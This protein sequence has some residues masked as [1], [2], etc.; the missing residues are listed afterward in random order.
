MENNLPNY[1][2]FQLSFFDKLREGT[3]KI[4]QQVKQLNEL[5]A[6]GFMAKTPQE[7]EN[8]VNYAKRFETDIRSTY[9][10]KRYN[11]CND[12]NFFYKLG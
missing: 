11:S 9:V 5:A 10:I 7:I 3:T 8:D 4:E 2:G 12:I 6:N 1:N